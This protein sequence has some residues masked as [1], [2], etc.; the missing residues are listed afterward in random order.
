DMV[1]FEWVSS[2]SDADIIVCKFNMYN[3]QFDADAYVS[4]FVS[5]FKNGDYAYC[6]RTRFATHDDAAQRELLSR[7]LAGAAR[8][9]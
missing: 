7:C 6:I 8:S 9:T 3:D 2:K 4:L 1:G 5:T